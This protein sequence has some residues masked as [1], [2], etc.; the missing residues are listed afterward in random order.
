MIRR[1]IERMNAGACATCEQS[2]RCAAVRWQ[3]AFAFA[4]VPGPAAKP[5]PSAAARNPLLAFI[6][7]L[8]R[9]AERPAKSR[10]PSF[11]RQVEAR[12][13]PLLEA[14]GIGIDRIAGE[15]GL[16]RQTLYRRLKAEG[17]T[18]E[19]VLD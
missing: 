19:R 4:G 7:E 17:L 13:E 3:Q 2:E 8:G 11:R 1:C 9:L 16:S 10:K 6:G 14:G 5:A 18:F 12:L 15:L